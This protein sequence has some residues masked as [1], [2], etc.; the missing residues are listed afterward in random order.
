MLIWN[1]VILQVYVLMLYPI[2]SA[3]I[4]NQLSDT[5]IPI[6]LWGIVYAAYLGFLM[7]F[8]V[9]AI[10]EDRLPPIACIILASEQVGLIFIKFL[11]T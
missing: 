8:P 10:I 5:R 7:Y 3:F 1:W 9:A 11:S 6:A 2:F 4:S